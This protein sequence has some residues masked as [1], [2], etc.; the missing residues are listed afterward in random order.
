MT[1]LIRGA[2][3]ERNGRKRA[4]TA[5]AVL[6]HSYHEGLALNEIDLLSQ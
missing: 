3:E 6:C 1:D 4:N 2:S 5:L